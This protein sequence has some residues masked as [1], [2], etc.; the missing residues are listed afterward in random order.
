[1]PITISAR[2]YPLLSRS[3][4]A[5]ESLFLSILMPN[6][7]IPATCPLRNSAVGWCWSARNSTTFIALLV[8]HALFAES[9]ILQVDLPK[10]AFHFCIATSTYVKAS[11]PPKVV[12]PGHLR[13]E[14]IPSTPPGVLPFVHLLVAQLEEDLKY[15]ERRKVWLSYKGAALLLPYRSCGFWDAAS[16][17][18]VLRTLI[19]R[20][21]WLR[22]FG[23]GRLNTQIVRW[24]AEETSM[25]YSGFLSSRGILEMLG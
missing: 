17:I 4:V 16:I 10:R 2:A 19:V 22:S 23:G 25:G 24:E 12:S 9:E 14:P 1:M 6:L 5:M 11:L 15:R 18:A 21:V 3:C 8:A 13:R 7:Q 20:C